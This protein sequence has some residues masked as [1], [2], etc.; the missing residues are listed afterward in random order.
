MI[1]LLILGALLAALLGGPF[2]PENAGTGAEYRA[3]ESST[4]ACDLGLPVGSEPT[5]SPQ[6][7]PLSPVFGSSAEMAPAAA[8]ESTL[9]FATPS[10]LDRQAG[11]MAGLILD[12]YRS[13]QESLTTP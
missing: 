3:P 13:F 2:A 10:A 12:K 9:R 8:P 1:R 5:F 4:T 11:L 6:A 7:L